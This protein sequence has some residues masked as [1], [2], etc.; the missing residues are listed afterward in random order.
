MT[1]RALIEHLTRSPEARE[2]PGLGLTI[3]RQQERVW[4]QDGVPKRTGP[5]H[6]AG[7]SGHIEGVILTDDGETLFEVKSINAYNF[8]KVAGCRTVDEAFSDHFFYQRYPAQGQVYMSGAGFDRML[9]FICPRGDHLNWHELTQE[10]DDAQV[11]ALAL[12]SRMVDDFVA[13]G[14]TP[15][16]VWIDRVCDHCPWLG[17]CFGAVSREPGE[18]ADLDDPQLSEALDRIEALS[19][20]VREHNRLKDYVKARCRE[21]DGAQCG[22]WTIT[23]KW[24]TR[25]AYSVNESTF[26]VSKQVTADEDAAA[27]TSRLAADL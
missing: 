22:R 9:W 15:D 8:G 10:R 6:G 23:G 14:K 7:C 21:V 24:Q 12:K 11:A 16:P 18:I 19:E 13:E 3:T 4:L 27:R 1:E 17:D 5:V 2:D 25:K 26:W 20:M